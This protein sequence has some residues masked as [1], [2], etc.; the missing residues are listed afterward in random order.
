[1]SEPGFLILQ[2]IASL[3]LNLFLLKQHMA[4]ERIFSQADTRQQKNLMILS[5]EQ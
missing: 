1:M 2:L 3:D 5:K 4:V